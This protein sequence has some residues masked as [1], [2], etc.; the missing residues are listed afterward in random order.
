MHIWD[1]VLT[2]PG[3]GDAASRP[4]L[5]R[6]ALKY[7]LDVNALNFCSFSLLALPIGPIAQSS[8]QPNDLALVAIP[9]LV[10]SSLVS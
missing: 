2:A 6:P 1:R 4:D 9:N 3:V 10:E 8:S 5:P 7:S